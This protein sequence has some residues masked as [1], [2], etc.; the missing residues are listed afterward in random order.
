MG[1]FAGPVPAM[2]EEPNPPPD[3]VSPLLHTTGTVG[4]SER[5]I[6]VVFTTYPKD[7][8]RPQGAAA[9]AR[10]C[11]SL[12]PLVPMPPPNLRQD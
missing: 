11:R 1:E 7:T 3:L 4:P 9:I 5:S 6:V 2:K 8:T 10:L 12:S